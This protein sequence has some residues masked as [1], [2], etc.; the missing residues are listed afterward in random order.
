MSTYAVGTRVRVVLFG[1]VEIT[2]TVDHYDPNIK[3]GRPGY[4]L[5][6]CSDGIEHWCYAEQVKQEKER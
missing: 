1:G 2:A 3:R 4:D 6:D 5:R